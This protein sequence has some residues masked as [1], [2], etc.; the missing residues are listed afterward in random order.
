MTKRKGPRDDG[1]AGDGYGY[2]PAK[3]LS[4]ICL[5]GRQSGRT[6]MTGQRGS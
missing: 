4:A 2:D 1:E 6:R 5:S 3:T